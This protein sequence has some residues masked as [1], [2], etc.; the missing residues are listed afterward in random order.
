MP[1]LHS[2]I[3]CLLVCTLHFMAESEEELKSLLLKAGGEG[4]DRG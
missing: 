3:Y 4:D 2:G 1:R